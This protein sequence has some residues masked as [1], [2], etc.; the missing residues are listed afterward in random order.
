[1]VKLRVVTGVIEGQVCGA[2][3]KSKREYSMVVIGQGWFW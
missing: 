2:G 3:K 1:M